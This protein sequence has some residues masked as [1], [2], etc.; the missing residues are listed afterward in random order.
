MPK[1]T[2][3]VLVEFKVGIARAEDDDKA[4]AV[5]P[6]KFTVE[7]PEIVPELD[8]FPA[9]LRV[10][11]AIDN[12]I[13]L[14]IVKLPLTSRV[15]EVV[16]LKILPPKIRLLYDQLVGK[17]PALN[18]IRELRLLFNVIV[19]EMLEV[20]VN[21]LPPKLFITFPEEPKVENE[22]V[23]IVPELFK[24]VLPLRKILPEVFM[25]VPNGM[26]IVFVKLI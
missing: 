21:E 6:V 2:V 9:K 7:S 26:V 12:V 11:E 24:V 23:L 8:R 22:P 17:V 10:L 14:F 4:C 15:D 20:T 3:F 13:P 18:V 25:V 19:P 5:V 16:L 1:V